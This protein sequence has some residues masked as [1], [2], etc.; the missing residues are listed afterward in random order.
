MEDIKIGIIGGSGI[1]DIEGVENVET[2]EVDTPYG[3]PSDKIIVGVLEGVKFAFLPRHGRGHKIS[4]TELNFRANIYALKKLGVEKVLSISAVGSLKEELKPRDFIIPDQ[5]FDRTKNRAST[6]FGDGLV[7]H[8][9]FAEPFCARLS[10][11]AYDTARQIGLS[12]HK[13][14]T[15]ICMEGPQFST[16]AESNVYRQLGFSVI[17][18]TALPEAKLAR[19][20]EMC[21]ITVALVTDYDCWKE[22]EEV[23]VEKILENL[24]ANSENAK[25]FI[26]T[27][28]P[29]LKDPDTCVCSSALATALITPADAVP[30]KTLEK[31]QLLVKKYIKN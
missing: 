16:K 21:Y 20:A 29:K 2:V 13:G 15:Y 1:Y 5:L 6:F 26:K 18:M 9:G 31:V 19:E 17:G 4:P 14:G 27:I 28:L 23:S 22:D 30:K 8:I 12:V 3:S 25:K 11:V 24:S 10:Q 7:A